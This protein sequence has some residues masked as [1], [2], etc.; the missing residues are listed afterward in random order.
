MNFRNFFSIS[1][2]DNL[3]FWFRIVCEFLLWIP[4]TMLE[5][6]KKI[7]SL[8]NQAC[9]NVEIRESVK[10]H[11]YINIHEWGGYP[12]ERS[13]VLKNGRVF[14]C[15]LKAQ[16]ESYQLYNGKYNIKTIVTLSDMKKSTYLEWI[17]NRADV[18]LSVD[19]AGY[20]F[21]GYEAAYN[22]V[23]DKGNHY[24]I[25][26]NSSINKNVSDYLD[27]YLKYMDEN[28]DVGILG[29]SMSKKYYQTLI[30]NNFRPHIQS[31]FLLTTINVLSKIIE[32]NNNKFPGKNINHK[33]LLIREGEVKI[34]QLALDLGYKLAVVQADGKVVKF[35]RKN[36]WDNCYSSLCNMNIDNRLF[37]EYPN[38]INPIIN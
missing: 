28:P 36:K 25:L 1:R 34:S 5:W 13:K 31:F 7:I 2:K 33:L 29:T 18:T 16:L 22:Y 24:I 27:G 10:K 11:V 4:L 14:E 8:T 20:D 6:I 21:S 17:R 32:K 37:V 15:G 35:G 23:K 19:N 38:R 12:I 26:S 9:D 30:R 3:S